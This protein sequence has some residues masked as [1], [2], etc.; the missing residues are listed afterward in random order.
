MRILHEPQ[1]FLIARQHFDAP[2]V[3][4]FM[5][6]EGLAWETDAASAAEKVVEVGGRVCYMSFG[7]GRKT[8]QEYIHNI[9]E[10]KHGSVIEHATWTLLITG[11]SRSLTHELIRHRAGFSYCLTGDTLIYSDHRWSGKRNGVKKRRLADIFAMTQTSHGRSR[12]KLLRLRCMDDKTR[13]FTTGAVAAVIYSGVKPVFRVE[14]E[15]GKTITCS[16]DHRFLTEAGW[17]P[18]HEIVGSLTLSPGGLAMTET[19]ATPIAVNGMAAY[20]DRAWLQEQYIIQNL[21]QETIAE[22]AGVSPHTIRVWVRKHNLQKPMGSWARGRVPWNKGKQYSAGWHHSEETKALLSQMKQAEKNPQWRSGITPQAI[23]LRRPMK[24][25]RPLVHQRDGYTCRL[26]QAV[27]GELTVHHVL[28]IWMRLDLRADMDNL[29]TLCEEC[30]YKVNGHEAEYADQFGAPPEAVAELKQR[31]SPRGKRTVTCKF[32]RIKSVTYM[33]EQDT[34]DIA[35]AGNNHNFVANG[36]LTHNSQLS[37]RYVDE[38]TA[39][40]VEPEAI[41]ASPEAHAVFER[42]AAAAQQAYVELVALLDQQFAGVANKTLRRKMARQA[43]RA[44]LPNATETK[45]VVTANARSWRHF[46]EMR[47]SPYSEPEIRRLAIMILRLLQGEAP[48]L[49]G[50]YEIV[51]AEDGS[52]VAVTAHGKV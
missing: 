24:E 32:I 4:R 41:A 3:D 42:A 34:Y 7:K 46:I 33:E 21:D 45:I 20:K 38:T 48:N 17:K 19:L 25:L 11:V 37:Q 26:C 1:V 49:F 30:H 35:M 12:L 18:L 50:D 9:L 52:E 5:A 16:R 13:T 40:F 47:A 22:L 43:A 8:N 15:D 14:L 44:V 51:P 6:G 29:V 10:A 36:I 2:T 28:P 31:E 27:G 23:V 39:D